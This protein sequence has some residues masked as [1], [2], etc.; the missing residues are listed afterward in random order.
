MRSIFILYCILILIKIFIPGNL[1][2]QKDT[3]YHPSVRFGVDVSY[4]VRMIF[5]P[6][7]RQY[8]ASVDFE[9]RKNWFLAM[10]GGI[11]DVGIS[12]ENFDYY[13]DGWFFRVGADFNILGRE[14]LDDND[15]V[16][17]GIRYG[18]GKQ[19]HGAD[20]VVVF[21]EYWGSYTTSVERTGFD[22]HWGE[23]AGGLKTELFANVFIGWS[24]RF[25]LILSGADHTPMQPYRIAGFGSGSNKVAFGLNYSIFYRI[26]F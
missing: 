9:F 22:F 5:E 17:F 14:T 2:S 12:R 10:E 8:E 11:I 4:P 13:S 3:V 7:M 1:Y 6:E 24:V 23:L 15:I 26:P 19:A 20:N 18:Y 25:K 16:F 21:D